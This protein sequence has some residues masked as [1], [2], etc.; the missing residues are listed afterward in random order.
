[1]KYRSCRNSWEQNV[2]EKLIGVV[3]FAFAVPA[4][5]PTNNR[6]K[7]IAEK[8]AKHAASTN[9]ELCPIFTQPDIAIGTE[10]DV[11]YIEEEPNAPSP[12]LRIAQE[13]V[14]WAKV[15]GIRYFWIIAA[16][17]HLW[18]CVRDLKMAIA[19]AKADITLL[20]PEEIKQSK[21]MSWFESQSTQYRTQSFSHWW[22]RELLLYL[23]PYDIYKHIAN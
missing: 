2:A 19:E 5:V 21:Y 18:R 15:R 11:Q 23:A 6:L 3:V 1:M 4:N 20:V 8:C 9:M 17:P 22:P 12:T 13:A 10:F 7:S 14:V 16:K